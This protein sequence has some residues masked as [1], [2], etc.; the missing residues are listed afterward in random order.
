[1]NNKIDQMLN[2]LNLYTVSKLSIQNENKSVAV[3]FVDDAANKHMV[4]FGNV[5]TYLFL[6]EDMLERLNDDHALDGAITYFR[7]HNSS[8]VAISH[9]EDGSI[10]E[11]AIASP[12][13]IL[14]TATASIMLEAKKVTI[15]GESYALDRLL[16]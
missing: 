12:N 4:E 15:N 16:H 13:I 10:E 7:N 2:A 9:Y 11:Q 14:N 5:D 6:D 3:E 1:M 8:I